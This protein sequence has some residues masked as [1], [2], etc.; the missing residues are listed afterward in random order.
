MRIDYTNAPAGC[1]PNPN[2]VTDAE[3]RRRCEAAAEQAKR[4]GKLI[5]ERGPLNGPVIAID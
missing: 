4:D 5:C 2:D 3:L 1:R